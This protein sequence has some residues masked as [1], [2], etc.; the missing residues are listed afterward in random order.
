MRPP[1]PPRKDRLPHFA[2][3][4]RHLSRAS[5]AHPPA[6][7][8]AAGDAGA[9]A[10]DDAER[11]DDD[12]DDNPSARAPTG[13]ADYDR[14][15]IEAENAMARRSRRAP[16]PADPARLSRSSAR[17]P[18]T[19]TLSHIETLTPPR[20]G[21]AGVPPPPARGG[22]LPGLRRR[23]PRR[24]R[25]RGAR[26]PHDFPTLRYPLPTRDCCGRLSL[27]RI[28]RQGSSRK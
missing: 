13:D 23:V 28:A 20:N 10:D 9:A 5:H 21:T 8:P 15:I 6:G 2:P 24:E 3:P 19:L 16:L 7:R 1:L 18:Q 11:F 22:A 17:C 4:G 25:L 27:H 12:A 26:S 14:E